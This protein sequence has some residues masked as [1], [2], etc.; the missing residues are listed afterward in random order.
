MEIMSCP[1]CGGNDIRY[2]LKK[3]AQFSFCYYQAAMYCH[4]C[5]TYGPRIFTET[6]EKN[7]WLGR[8]YKIASDNVYKERAIKAWNDRKNIESSG[9][10][11]VIFCDACK[12]H[13]D[14]SGE[15][16]C[17]KLKMVCPDDSEFY[18]K[19]GEKKES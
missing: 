6:V 8:R 13:C 4:E 7:S 19:Y 11:I 17:K 14:I 10:R 12:Y 3:V 15:H 1:F 2:S 16:Y 5:H 9:T 18:C